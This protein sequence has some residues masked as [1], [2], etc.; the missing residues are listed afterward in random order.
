MSVLPPLPFHCTSDCIK[1]ALRHAEVRATL[2]L[3]VSS[4]VDSELGHVGGQHERIEWLL[5]GVRWL[6]TASYVLR[7]GWWVGGWVA[8]WLGGHSSCRCGCQAL[9]SPVGL[10]D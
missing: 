8:G 5:S 3:T 2:A 9:A 4:P 6:P 7:I 1:D 10:V